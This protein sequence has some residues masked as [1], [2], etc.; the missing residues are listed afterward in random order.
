MS[1]SMIEGVQP[2]IGGIGSRLS[3]PLHIGWEKLGMETKGVGVI[4]YP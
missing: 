3:H 4:S 2:W 1:S